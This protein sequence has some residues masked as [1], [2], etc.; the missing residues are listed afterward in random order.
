MSGITVEENRLRLDG[1]DIGELA[2][3]FGTP[4]YA[5]GG[6]SIRDGVRSLKRAI[7]DSIEIYYSIKAN[8]SIAI[9]RLIHQ[10]GLDGAEIASSGELS[11]AI[12]SGFKPANIL[13]AG[14]GKTDAEIE[15]AIQAGV[16]QINTESERE[17]QRIDRI[18]RGARVVQPV[19][20]RVNI[21]ERDAGHGLIQ[22]GGG[23]Q[24]FGI[25]ESRVADAIRMLNQLE[26]VHF[27]GLH[28]MLGSQVLDADQ[29]LRS[30]E[31]S[32]NMAQVI[33]ESAGMEM[34]TI[35][36]GGGLG[37]PHK[38]DDPVFDLVKFGSGLN[39]LIEQSKEHTAFKNT[40]FMIEPGRILLSEHGLYLSRVIEVKESFGQ[41][42]AI[43]DGGIHH[44]LL[45]ITANHYRVCIAD[46]AHV[47]ETEPVMLGGPLCTSADQWVPQVELPDAR[48]DDIV[49]MF[50]S[51]AYG[52]TASMTMFL[53]HETPAEVLILDGECMVIRQRSEPED[54]LRGQ[55]IPDSLNTTLD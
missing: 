42:V 46:R 45:P 51:G 16:G 29:M 11:A 13:F 31:R 36:F 47:Q 30:C 19:G 18:A 38:D 8:P 39:A 50:N 54:V 2:G 35:N 33:A 27:A 53:S 22:T 41:K 9:C 24:K 44:A 43:V 7:G 5:Y 14:P 49:A 37:V 55:H 48:V 20:I 10:S 40:R 34:P 52:L 3:R 32:L 23:T 17:I 1:I 4:V 6:D 12:Q 26:H 15:H 25:D 21:Q 28:T